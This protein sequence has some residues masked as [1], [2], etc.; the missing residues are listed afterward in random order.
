MVPQLIQLETARK[1]AATTD[2][3]HTGVETPALISF[4]L[5]GEEEKKV[6]QASLS[7]QD[8][9]SIS[10]LEARKKLLL[11]CHFL[12]LALE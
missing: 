9:L 8:D 11:I 7:K 5:D 4:H 12:T 1:L 3:G 2:N 6:E 10:R